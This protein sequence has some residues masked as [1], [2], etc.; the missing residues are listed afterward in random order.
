MSKRWYYSIDTSQSKI[1]VDQISGEM[2]ELST[3][4]FQKTGLSL[5]QCMLDID[6][7]VT[8]Y[9][10]QNGY[11]ILL[12]KCMPNGA[13][14]DMIIARYGDMLDEIGSAGNELIII[15]P[16]LFTKPRKDTDRDEYV[17]RLSK[18]LI[19]S[20]CSSLIVYMN[21]EHNFSQDIV[22]RVQKNT[23]LIITVNDDKIFHDRFWIANRKK[24]FVSGTSLNGAGKHRAYLFYI[25]EDDLE[26]IL[27]TLN[28]IP[29]NKN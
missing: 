16:Y 20:K 4:L 19:N 28:L 1:P 23:G 18:I 2:M 26:D 8:E 21:K 25:P 12:E 9:F 27:T 10:A 15:D 17:D 29:S 13:S 24:G 7:I 5:G 11:Q 6:R 22:D 14:P 3:V